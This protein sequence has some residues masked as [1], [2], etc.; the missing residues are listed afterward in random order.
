MARRSKD[1]G[2]TILELVVGFAVLSVLASVTVAGSGALVQ[3]TRS[4]HE[5]DLA[6]RRLESVLEELRTNPPRDP[7]SRDL[8]GGERLDVTVLEPG[9][10]M[11]TLS[12]DGHSLTTLLAVEDER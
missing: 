1:R 12:V 9:L 2:I 6:I 8:P 11:L 7:G 5:E 4:A 3:Q 10:W